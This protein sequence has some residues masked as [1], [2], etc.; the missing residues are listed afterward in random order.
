M[1]AGK[2]RQLKKLLKGDRW[3]RIK[4]AVYAHWKIIPRSP[5]DYALTDVDILWMYFAL[6]PEEVA[7]DVSDKGTF[8]DANFASDFFRDTGID[9]SEIPDDAWTYGAGMRS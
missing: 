5:Q 8:T 1:G 3:E 4:G 9:L 7:P 6:H 2:A